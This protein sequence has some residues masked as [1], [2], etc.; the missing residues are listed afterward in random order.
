MCSVE[1]ASNKLRKRCKCFLITFA[2]PALG[3][4]SFSKNQNAEDMSGEAKRL[5][6]AK[7]Y[8]LHNYLHTILHLQFIRYGKSLQ[9]NTRNNCNQTTVF[10]KSSKRNHLVIFQDSDTRLVGVFS[11]VIAIYCSLQII[12]NFLPNRKTLRCVAV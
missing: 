2:S 12:L 5:F 8:L 11:A 10:C 9:N 4:F 3:H 7:I 6:S 1:F